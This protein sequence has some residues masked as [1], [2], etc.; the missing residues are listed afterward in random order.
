MAGIVA[1]EMPTVPP[2][3]LAVS[4]PPTQVVAALGMSATTNA[5]G[6]V[7][8]VSISDAPVSGTDVALVKVMVNKDD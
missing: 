2:P 3:G 4:V 5:P 8:R 6:E 1:P 7:G